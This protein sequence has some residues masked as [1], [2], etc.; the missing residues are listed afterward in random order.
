MSDE[1]DFSRFTLGPRYGSE[2]MYRD[3]GI[4]PGSKIAVEKDGVPY[5]D[6]VQSV[7][8]Q[9]GEPAI[10]P[11]LSRWQQ[12]V[13]RFTPK[14]WR[15]P[16]KPIREPTLPSVEIS[17]GPVSDEVRGTFERTQANLAKAGEI[18]NGLIRKD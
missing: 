5:T 7:R 17:T 14:R 15:K 1:A 6:T 8:W 4:V 13:R 18:I 16:L 2:D 10:W 3:M 12:L 9:S 11:E